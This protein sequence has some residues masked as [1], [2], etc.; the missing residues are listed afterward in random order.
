MT[1]GSPKDAGKDVR[2]KAKERDPEVDLPFLVDPLAEKT[3]A[4]E[5]AMEESPRAKEKVK[6]DGKDTA[7]ASDTVRHTSPLTACLPPQ[8]SEAASRSYLETATTRQ[9]TTRKPVEHTQSCS[10][11]HKVP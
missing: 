10:V 9:T 7:R 11:T 5:K 3:M 4:K 2:A 8:T 6:V 1:T